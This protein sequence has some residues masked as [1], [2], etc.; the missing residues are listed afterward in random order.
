MLW[1][2]LF[3]IL[4]ALLMFS[5]TGGDFSITVF[6]SSLFIQF[7]S[8]FFIFSNQKQPFSLNKIF[9]LF[10]FFFFGI[11]PYLQF[12]TNTSINGARILNNNEFLFMNLLIIIILLIYQLVYI[13]YF[14]NKIPSLLSKTS[15]KFHLREKLTAIQGIKLLLLSFSAFFIV[16]YI[17][18]FN[19]LGMLLRGAGEIGGMSMTQSTSL[20]ISR[21]VQPIPMMCLLYFLFSKAKN[22]FLMT[23]LVVLTVITNSPFSMSRFMTAA[24]YIPLL[25]TLS[26]FIRKKNVFSLVFI[27]GLLIVFPFLNQFR[28]YSSDLGLTV[29]IDLSMFTTGHFDSFYNFALIVLEDIV[30]WGKQLL[31]VIFF[32]VPRGIWPS[33]PIGSGSFLAELGLI[34]FP[35]ASANYFAEGYINFGFMGI[36]L[37]IIFLAY[38]T[39]K[40]DKLYWEVL[41]DQNKNYFKVIYYVVLG[42]LFLLLRGDLMAG[43]AYILSLVLS[44]FIVKKVVN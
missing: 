15:E 10:C 24:L 30:T 6:T 11:A 13:F 38:L 16:L 34:V 4:S 35:N 2:Y 36:L 23:L 7:F 12:A 42:M 43:F 8:L 18:N 9:Y 26:G 17:R 40:L 5:V 32:W 20:I 39:A 44:I 33:K 25:L 19:I 21:V 3:I 41:V 31:G 28:N 29:G 14:N 1:V 27:G 22:I 37:F